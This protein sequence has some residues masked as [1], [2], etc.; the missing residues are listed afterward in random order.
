MERTSKGSSFKLKSGNKPSMSR[1][2]GISP[3]KKIVEGRDQKDDRGMYKTLIN[4]KTGEIR[5][6][7]ADGFVITKK[8][9]GDV[10]PRTKANFS[11]WTRIDSEKKKK[12]RDKE[13][14][15]SDIQNF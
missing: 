5:K 10:Q 13:V 1:L 14:G 4:K 12:A 3:M 8:G 6:D 9:K 11:D 2:A 15:E 7:Y